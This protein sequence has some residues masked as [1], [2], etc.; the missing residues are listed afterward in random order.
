MKK[1][2][3][4]LQYVFMSAAIIVLTYAAVVA[5]DIIKILYI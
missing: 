1:L 4:R 3:E 2:Y 5:Y